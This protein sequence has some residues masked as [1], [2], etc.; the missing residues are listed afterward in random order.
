MNS[1][2]GM[3]LDMKVGKNAVG[4]VFEA[5]VVI[6]LECIGGEKFIFWGT[7]TAADFTSRKV[8]KKRTHRR[9]H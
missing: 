3:K 4:S 7:A 8:D 1:R 5:L 9:G 6:P 2:R